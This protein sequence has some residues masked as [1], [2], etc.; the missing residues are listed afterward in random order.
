MTERVSAQKA[1]DRTGHSNFPLPLLCQYFESP[2]PFEQV[3]TLVPLPGLLSHV[4]GGQP[5]TEVSYAMT[6]YMLDI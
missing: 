3:D 5:V 2:D 6:L 1:F 4:L